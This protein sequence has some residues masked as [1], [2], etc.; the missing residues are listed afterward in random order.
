MA[1]IIPFKGILYNREKINDLSKVVAPPYDV[2]SKQ[3][4]ENF[5]DSHP[6]NIIRLIL[7][8]K[9]NNDTDSDNRYTRAAGFFN[10]WVSKGILLRDKSPALYFTAVDFSLENKTVTRFGIITLVEIEPFEKG[11]VLPHESTFSKVKSERLELIKTCHTNFSPIFSL[12]SDKNNI[13]N[14]LKDDAFKNKT[15]IDIVDGKGQRHRMWRITDSAICRNIM[16]DMKGKSLFIADGHH[17]YET[18]LNYRNWV[19]GNTN[20][21]TADHPAN[22]IM[23]Y[24]CSM[25]DPGLV[26]LPA[27]RMLTAIEDSKRFLFIEKAKEYF[28][29]TTIPFKEKEHENAQAEFLLSLK[30]D[31]S[32]STIG[33]FMKDRSEFYVLTLKANVMEQMFADEL[34]ESLRTLDVIVLTRLIFMELLGFN[35]AALDNEKIIS[36]SSIEKD[37]IDAVASKKC[38]IAFIL[39]PTKIDQVRK[40]AKE[41]LTMPRKST[42]FYPKVITGLVQN[43]LLP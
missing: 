33:V 31:S 18:A 19:S 27:H 7:G 8:K 26:I 39:N 20:D 13:L 41:G 6:N 37:A 34:P 17:R 5:Y 40:I 3:E 14:L 11:V 32:T 30:K 35:N 9:S 28:D 16:D 21:F 25:E 38:D 23:M 4:Q 15:D 1:K 29:I 42:Y 43:S 36:Y 22:Y 2:I 12:Y 24:L 10:D